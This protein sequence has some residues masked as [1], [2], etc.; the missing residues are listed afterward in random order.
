M[1]L[2]PRLVTVCLL[3]CMP[4]LAPAKIVFESLRDGEYNIY[5]MDDDGSNVQRLT[6]TQWP[7][8]DGKPAWSPDG[9]RIAFERNLSKGG[10]QPE[11][12]AM[13]EDGS[14]VQQ[15]THYKVLSGWGAWAP[16]GN[17]IAFT[18]NKSGGW[19]IYVIDLLTQAVEQLTDNPG[20]W[21]WAGGPSWSP[22][23]KHIAYQQVRPGLTTIYVMRAD[24]TG[25][26]PLVPSDDWYRYSPR[27][28]PDSKSVLYVEA[29]YDK[30]AKVAF[31]LIEAR[32]VIQKHGAKAR[33]FLKTPKKWMIHS[34]CWMDNGRQVLIAAEEFAA[35]DK[36]IDIYRYQLATGKL[37][38][39]TT[40][41]K[42][43]LAPHWI[44]DTVFSVTPLKKKAIQWGTLKKRDKP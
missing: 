38:N 31:K 37:T 4:P 39:L 3:L 34:A 43:D 15:L 23:G 44:S 19:E 28:A 6:F 41:P 36:Q 1:T 18:S 27:W 7:Q 12:F 25:Q 42:D 2:L 10:Q 30:D 16:D 17:R 29:L 5:V 40:D 32:V 11:L 20:N 14:N 35:P 21:E 26:D 13:G 24:G 8:S 22:D 9:T 33:R